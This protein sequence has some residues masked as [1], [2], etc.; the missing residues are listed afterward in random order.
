MR[1]LEI[2]LSRKLPMFRIQTNIPAVDPDEAYDSRRNQFHSTRILAQLEKHIRIL[3]VQRLLGV[4][5][6]DLYV[7]GMNFVF[8]EARRPGQVGVISTHRLKPQAS[9]DLGL[10]ESRIVKEAV[11]EV[12]HMMGLIHCLDPLCV[13][14]FSQNLSDTD[15]K[16]ADF[17]KNCTLGAEGI[18]NE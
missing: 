1:G 9:G 11:H 15:S 18:R 8:G 16:N 14:F 3:P 7:P 13:M 10:F 6:L 2:A 12:G 17:C 5:A 4:T